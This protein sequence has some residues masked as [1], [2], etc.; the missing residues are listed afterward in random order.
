MLFRDHPLLS[1]QQLAAAPVV[2]VGSRNVLASSGS[3]CASKDSCGY[4]FTSP[5]Y[6][7]QKSS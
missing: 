6:R 5:S 2:D 3:H 7:G 1:Y 4:L